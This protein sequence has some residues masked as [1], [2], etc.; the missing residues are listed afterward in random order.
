MSDLVTSESIDLKAQV[1]GMI[2]V[3]WLKAHPFEEK[4]IPGY[5]YGAGDVGYVSAECAELLSQSRT[6]SNNGHDVILGPYIEILPEGWTAPVIEKVMTAEGDYIQVK[7][8][9]THSAFAYSAG[10]I[11]TVTSEWAEKLLQ[12]EYVEL[13]PIEQNRGMLS[14]LKKYFK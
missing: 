14:K 3:K 4:G 8:L 11:G 12:G 13:I 2:K 7:F 6:D 1:S 9:R 5:S 10:M